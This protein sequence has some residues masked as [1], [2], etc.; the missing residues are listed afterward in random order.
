MI[1]RARLATD[2]SPL[3][4]S[5]T[6]DFK[7]EIKYLDPKKTT[8]SRNAF[9]ELVV[10][11]KDGITLEKVSPVRSF[12][13]TSPT[14]FIAFT[15]ED[16]EELALMEDIELLDRASRAALEEELEKRYFIPRI[17]R[18]KSLKNRFGVLS[19]EVETDRGDRAFDVRE[20]DDIRHL[21][22]TSRV[23]VRDVDGN[24]YDIP[25]TARLDA[26]SQALLETV[27]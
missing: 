20:R 23:L 2:P 4:M 18:V 14:K 10:E 19:W 22:G 25:D 15:N 8:V 27:V 3:A 21:P 13:L 12:P 9:N 7:G 6:P 5:D 11:E 1:H 24:R 26:A 16:G 17:F